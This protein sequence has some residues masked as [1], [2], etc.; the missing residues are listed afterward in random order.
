MARSAGRRSPRF[1]IIVMVLAA[2]TILTVDSRDVPVISS[3]RSTAADVFAPVGRGAA[4]VTEPVRDWWG[5]LSDYGRLEKENE[6]LRARIDEL[7]GTRARDEGAAEELRRLQEQLDLPYAPDI[8]SVLAQVSA[9]P[10]SNFDNNIVQID[11]GTTS[12]IAEGMPVVT[13]AGL[14]GTVSSVTR[15]TAVI[16]LLTDPEL[17][18]GLLLAGTG[19]YAIGRGTGVNSAFIVDQGVFTSGLENSRYPKG[20]PIGRVT[21]VS[22]SQSDQSQKLEV[23]LFADLIGLNYV[24]VLLWQPA[25]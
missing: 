23:R 9:G 22:R 4:S 7:E 15:S 3:I 20:I 6:E 16:R 19:N 8:G 5:G 21:S 13:A 1:T 10:Y 18:V 24:Q 17:R 12:G 14:V 25:A 2:V 11:K